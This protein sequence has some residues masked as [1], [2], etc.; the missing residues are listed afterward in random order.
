[1]N[2]KSLNC[3]RIFCQSSI[4]LFIYLFLFSCCLEKRN[5]QWYE[6]KSQIKILW[7]AALFFSGGR[8]PIQFQ[9]EKWWAERKK[10]SIQET[11]IPWR[12]QWPGYL[13][14]PVHLLSVLVLFEFMF[15][16]DSVTSHLPQAMGLH[17]PMFLNR[18]S[19]LLA[20]ECLMEP[21]DSQWDEVG[22]LSQIGVSTW[23]VPYIYCIPCVLYIHC[24]DVEIGLGL[25]VFAVDRGCNFRDIV[26]SISLWSSV[27][28]YT[29][30]ILGGFNII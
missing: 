10:S 27:I 11:E 23:Y 12:A 6:R 26:I 5:K 17:L 13:N 3:C 19:H 2:G 28:S 8:A 7:A 29:C 15:S 16:C 18:Q 20:L 1:M 9:G 14:Q 30:N 22:L 25:N 24:I 4:F 21:E